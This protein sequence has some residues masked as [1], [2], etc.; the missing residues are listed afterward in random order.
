MAT[1]LEKALKRELEVEGKA[2]M[3]TIAPEGLKLV[4][5]GHRK[6]LELAWKDL[7]SGDAGLAAA[8]NASVEK[9]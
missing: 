8:L 7:L 2:Y 5:K 4:E 3:L 6:G 1:K 9:S